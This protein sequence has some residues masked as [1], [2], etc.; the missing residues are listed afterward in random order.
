MNCF[1]LLSLA[2]A[3]FTKAT[4]HKGQKQLP[5]PLIKIKMGNGDDCCAQQLTSSSVAVSAYASQIMKNVALNMVA[6]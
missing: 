3:I 2:L 4:L 6:D 1:W 5:V